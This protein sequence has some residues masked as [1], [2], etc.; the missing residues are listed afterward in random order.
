MHFAV[1]LLRK[2]MGAVT[3]HIQ[4]APA[5]VERLCV[6]VFGIAIPSVTVEAAEAAADASS[7]VVPTLECRFNFTGDDESSVPLL[8]LGGLPDGECS[9][10]P[11]GEAMYFGIADG[12]PGAVPIT[13]QELLE[14]LPFISLATFRHY[15][16]EELTTS[17]SFM[18]STYR[19]V[20]YLQHPLHEAVAAALHQPNTLSSSVSLEGF[21][22]VGCLLRELAF[23][24]RKRS[25]TLKGLAAIL[26]AGDGL[27]E[28]D[29]KTN[30]AYHYGTAEQ[31]VKRYF[32]I[33]HET[34]APFFSNEYSL[35]HRR[36]F[37]GTK[38]LSRYGAA[39]FV[40][41]AMH[42]DVGCVAPYWHPLGS[43]AAQLAPLFHAE[44]TPSPSRG[45][46]EVGWHKLDMNGPL[47]S[48]P[49]LDSELMSRYMKESGAA[50]PH[51][52][53]PLDT[54]NW[55]NVG[56]FDRTAG[57]SVEQALPMTS[58]LDDGSPQ[59]RRVTVAGV[60]Y[61]TLHNALEQ[62]G[63]DDA[64]GAHVVLP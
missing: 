11:K 34:A 17:A 54:S 32:D 27:D 53:F 18:D 6:E 3:K 16:V 7:C 58:H 22:G 57:S 49:L 43:P 52:P 12:L 31:S 23:V 33:E 24:T 48:S 64:T 8:I 40:G 55:L 42:E 37:H 44:H 51:A 61:N 41:C 15:T 9:S 36:G 59:K 28:R 19:R 62:I 63:V 29:L 30:F 20:S 38:F 39:V 1:P 4:V 50:S 45:V 14:H 26:G 2:E 10:M 47:S 13:H 21:D 56:L 46:L 35:K 25:S 60:R 5:A